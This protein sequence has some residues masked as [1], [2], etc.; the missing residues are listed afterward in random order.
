MLLW[1]EMN[2]PENLSHGT[3]AEV[4]IL[5]CGVL[6]DIVTKNVINLQPA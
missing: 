4:S 2:A 6:Q 1:F 3:R 5:L